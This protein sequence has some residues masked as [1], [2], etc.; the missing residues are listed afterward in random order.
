M[1]L[2][3]ERSYGESCSSV[4][5]SGSGA[6]FSISSFTGL[7]GLFTLSLLGDS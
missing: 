6:D 3:W 1:G 4:L 5:G 7:D 2:Y